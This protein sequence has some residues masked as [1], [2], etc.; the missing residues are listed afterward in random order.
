MNT[1]LYKDFRHIIK[2][3]YSYRVPTRDLMFIENLFDDLSL[4]SATNFAK[5]NS[6]V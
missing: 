1:Y 3:K 6:I 5:L 2:K 4:Y